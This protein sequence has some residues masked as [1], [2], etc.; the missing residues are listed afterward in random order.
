VK[1]TGKNGSARSWGRELR[2]QRAPV[3]RN[4]CSL[5]AGLRQLTK[6]QSQYR[7]AWDASWRNIGACAGLLE[8]ALLE[9]LPHS[10]ARARSFH[11]LQALRLMSRFPGRSRLADDLERVKFLC[12]EIWTAMFGKTV[13]NL[14]TNHRGVF[15][16]QDQELRTLSRLSCG[17]D[18]NDILQ[19]RKG[20]LAPDDS[21]K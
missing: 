7:G 2:V 20:S 18:Q 21:E 10:I 9:C 8:N 5:P 6:H 14:R 12:K 16:L 4:R 11:S 13:T 3:S 17:V 1:A 15:V 19:V